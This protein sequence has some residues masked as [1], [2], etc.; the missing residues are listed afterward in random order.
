EQKLPFTDTP[1]GEWYY[2]AVKY[3]YENGLMNGTGDGTQFSPNT[4]LTRGMVVTVIYRAERSPKVTYTSTFL[5][6]DEGKYY[7]EAALWAYGKKI[8]NGTGFDDW[9]EP[10]FSPDRII[11]REELATMF[12]RYAEYKGVITENDSTLA[13][14]TDSASVSDWAKAAM[15]WAVSCGLIT[16]TGSGSTLSPKD[17]AT[18]SQF[19]TIFH[20]FKT[21]PFEYSVK[22]NVPMVKSLYTEPDY[23]YVE[24][25]DIYVATDGNDSNPGTKEAPLATFE[26]AVKKISQIKKNGERKVAFMAGDYGIT[27]VTMDNAYTGTAESPITYC[28]YGDGEVYFTNGIFVSKSAFTS[29]DESDDLSRFNK[30]AIDAIK[31]VDLS[32]LPGG[33]TVT[34]ESTLFTNGKFCNTARIPNKEG[35]SE[36]Y[37]PGFSNFVM[38]ADAPYSSYEEIVEKLHS[39]EIP[40]SEV[41]NYLYQDKIQATRVLKE[42]LDSYHS[43]D[44]VQL[45][46]YIS[47]VWAQ[48]IFDIADYDKSTGIVTFA[49]PTEWGFYA[50]VGEQTTIYIG[51]V[52]EELD[53]EG[54]YW[55]D[56][57]TNTLYVYAPE[58]D[59]YIATSGT[60]IYAY[61][62]DYMNIVNLNFRCTTD[63]PIE[64]DYSDNVTI[65]Q[66]NFSYVSGTDGVFPSFCLD[67]TVKN[68]EFE[69]FSEYGLAIK[70]SRPG[71]RADYDYMA[72]E[73]QNVVVENNLF[74]DI[75]LTEITS[76]I[77]AVKLLNHVIGV[78]IA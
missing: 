7:T 23:P 48:E 49:Q 9:G 30:S 27:N 47:K 57:E 41:D 55:I 37:Y 67:L 68:C 44:G 19:A 18:R 71:K 25:A 2:N 12:I 38:R 70:G 28:A 10:Y 51:N 11:T 42:K 61:D 6:V 20:R 22:Y 8:V 40:A 3:V 46:G 69:Y 14:F 43:L 54:E 56:Y 32:S 72:L 4:G 63:S 15:T 74:H 76:D 17:T 35:I 75:S 60:F 53:Y 21:L 16:G 78:K 52:S 77:A 50:R 64:I 45:G 26:A 5:D 29:I 1:K 62:V 33:D 58:D 24:D 66:C 31:K 36:R 13:K 65:D 34:K 59:Y 39:G 73:S